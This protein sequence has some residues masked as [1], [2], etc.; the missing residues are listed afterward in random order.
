MQSK[1]T[2]PALAKAGS[3]IAQ[4]YFNR[5]R[6]AYFGALLVALLMLLPIGVFAYVLAVV[7]MITEILAWWFR[8]K[9]EHYHRLSRE[10]MRR[11]MLLNAFGHSD[12]SL[13]VTDLLNSFGEEKLKQKAEQLDDKFYQKPYYEGNRLLDNLQESAFWSKH[14]FAIAAQRTI[15]LLVLISF[16]VIFIVFLIEPLLINQDISLI[17]KI[18]VVFLA[19][20]IADELST[21]FAWREAANRCEAVDRRVE[22]IL[23]EANEPSQ[24]AILAIFSDYA[25]ATAAAPPIPK[26][27]YEEQWNHLDE[28][29]NDRMAA[30]QTIVTDK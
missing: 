16:A 14:L 27:I 28:S 11:A 2:L 4:F 25:V 5:R 24:E 26:R 15:W 6:M 21:A 1:P 17:P 7:A 30:R 13:D 22:K 12:E 20:V 19:F 23:A 18:I 9:G 3:E 8:N 10:L 29:W